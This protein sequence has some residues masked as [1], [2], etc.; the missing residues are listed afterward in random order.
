MYI[1][2]LVASAP[3]TPSPPFPAP[4]TAASS[5]PRSQSASAPTTIGG[6]LYDYECSWWERWDFLRFVEVKV[7]AVLRLI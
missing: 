6:E 1:G 3:V 2:V 5:S 7:V 4:T